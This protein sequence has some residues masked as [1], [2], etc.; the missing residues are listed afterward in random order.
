MTYVR[1]G[2]DACSP[3]HA[4]SMEQVCGRSRRNPGAAEPPLDI[5]AKPTASTASTFWRKCAGAHP[6]VDRTPVSSG[7]PLDFPSAEHLIDSG[8][9]FGQGAFRF[10]VDSRVGLSRVTVPR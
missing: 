6:A 3:V 4:S 7:D 9:A 10:F 2:A 1:I 5:R 8:D